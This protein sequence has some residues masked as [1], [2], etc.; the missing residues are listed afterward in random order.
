MKSN[1]KIAIIS[2]VIVSISLAGYLYYSTVVNPPKTTIIIGMHVPLTGAVAFTGDLQAKGGILAVE[3]I[4]KAG[5]ILGMKVEL[6]TEDDE[7]KPEVG[8][9]VVQKMITQDKVDIVC[10]GISSVVCL[11]A[12]DVTASYKIPYLSMGPSSDAITVKYLSDT[13]KY[14]GYFR[15]TPLSADAYGKSWVVWLKDIVSDGSWVPR[16]TKYAILVENT[17]FGRTNGKA[18]DD[19]MKLE[20]PEWQQVASEIV[21]SDE[22]SFYEVLTKIKVADPSILCVVQ[23]SAASCAALTKQFQE[24]ELKALFLSVFIASQKSYVDL[25]GNAATGVVWNL[26]SAFTPKFLANDTKSI[27]FNDK[28]QERFGVSATQSSNSLGQYECIYLIK[29]AYEK[30][31]STDPDAFI[32]AMEQVDFTY[33][34]RYVFEKNHCA[35]WGV[36]YRPST[37]GQIW[38]NQDYP[39]WPPELAEKLGFDFRLPPWLQ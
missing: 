31:G 9:S 23:T 37:I 39:I 15:L 8:V 17:D 10:G 26:N 38:E 22:S 20:M 29:T 30:A 5:G 24:K 13:N 35:K 2:I 6:V 32:K 25:A 4:N 3:E 12:M 7:Y 19:Y 18:F 1:L 33:V 14:K 16:N 21:A 36:E 28:F 27:E 11:S 34:D